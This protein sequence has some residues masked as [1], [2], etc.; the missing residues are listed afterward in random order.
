MAS[1]LIT[2]RQ[3]PKS[4]NIEIL[5]TM[6]STTK[7]QPSKIRDHHGGKGQGAEV[8]PSSS[9]FPAKI[10]ICWSGGIPSLSCI[11]ALTLS[12]VSELSTSKV[13]VFPVKVFTKICIPPHKCSIRF[14]ISSIPKKTLFI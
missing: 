4:T 3:K 11:L 7:S 9:C 6:D 1:K 12:I 5:K 14:M 13:M 10:S 8:L 2:D